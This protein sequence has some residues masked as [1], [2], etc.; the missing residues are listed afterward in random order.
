MPPLLS[1][2][3]T[4]R[5][6]VKF[7]SSNDNENRRKKL[8]T[9]NN[10]ITAVL[11]VVAVHLQQANTSTCLFICVYMLKFYLKANIFCAFVMIEWR[12]RRRSAALFC[13]FQ[14][15]AANSYAK[16]FWCCYFLCACAHGRW[17]AQLTKNMNYYSPMFDNLSSI[18]FLSLL[19]T[20][21]LLLFWLCDNKKFCGIGF[22]WKKNSRVLF[23]S[24]FLQFNSFRCSFFLPCPFVCSYILLVFLMFASIMWSLSISLY[25]FFVILSMNK[26][27]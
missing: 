7:C 26:C 19:F 15:S 20:L 9:L 10:I 3:S 5:K 6:K 21:F 13:A 27:R 11:R 8:F 2:L 17:I 1:V 25:R 16:K 4:W 18:F 14:V 23:F 24:S 12:R 22:T